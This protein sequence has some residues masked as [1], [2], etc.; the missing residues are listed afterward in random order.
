MA[1]CR[2]KFFPIRETI[3][4]TPDPDTYYWIEIELTK[5]DKSTDVRK[6]ESTT[7]SGVMTSSLY[8]RAKVYSCE[9]EPTND[10]TTAAEMEMFLASCENAEEFLMTNIDDGSAEMTC[11]LVGGSGRN[12]QTPHHLGKFMYSFSAREVL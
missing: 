2:I 8:Y 1:N 7:L 6:R 4:P 12:R 9:T 3:T 10:T 11:Q 5:F